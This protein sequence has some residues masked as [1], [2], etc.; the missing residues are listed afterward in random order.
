MLRTGSTVANSSEAI[1][2]AVGTCAPRKRIA[3]QRGSCKYNDHG[4]PA[5]SGLR[6]VIKTLL[7]TTCPGIPVSDRMCPVQEN[8]RFD[9]RNL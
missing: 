8:Y 4:V 2:R 7:A 3:A 1:E 9:R 6:G 5:M